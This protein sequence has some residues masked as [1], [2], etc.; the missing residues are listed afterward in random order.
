MDLVRNRPLSG[1]W[2][3]CFGEQKKNRH[4]LEK[5][6]FVQLYPNESKW[7][8][9]KYLKL[10]LFDKPNQVLNTKHGTAIIWVW[11]KISVI[12]IHVVGSFQKRIPSFRM[13]G[14]WAVPNRPLYVSK[15]GHHWWWLST[16]IWD[17]LS[18]RTRPLEGNFGISC[19]VGNNSNSA[20]FCYNYGIYPGPTS[21]NWI[22]LEGAFYT[23]PL[24][25]EI[26]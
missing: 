17:C 13:T 16:R 26:P 18:S 1:P 5:V 12:W 6:F 25:L 3:L 8:I 4:G 19:Q 15:K 7:H 23:K 14:W 9:M 2:W 11:T 10:K 20:I 22:L 21:Q 24:Y